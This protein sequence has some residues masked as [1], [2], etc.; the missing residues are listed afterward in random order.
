MNVKRGWYAGT[1]W[2]VTQSEGMAAGRTPSLFR[3]ASRTQSGKLER[4]CQD[5]SG[6]EFS[7]GSDL[8][9]GEHDALALGR[10][11]APEDHA[12]VGPV[13]PIALGNEPELGVR[14]LGLAPDGEAAYPFGR[15]RAVQRLEEAVEGG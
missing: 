15:R 1:N 7:S 10:R 9:V 4:H 13:N 6:N 12:Q 3:I 2:S 8:P 5:F 11:K 14:V